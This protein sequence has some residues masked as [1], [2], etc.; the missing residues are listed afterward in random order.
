MRKM[1]S[2]LG[3]NSS[4]RRCPHNKQVNDECSRCICFQ[5][6]CQFFNS[7]S[8]EMT[9][10]LSTFFI[11]TQTSR[12]AGLATS[13]PQAALRGPSRLPRDSRLNREMSDRGNYHPTTR[14]NRETPATVDEGCSSGE[15]IRGANHPPL[16]PTPNQYQS[17]RTIAASSAV[18]VFPVADQSTRGCYLSWDR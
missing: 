10:F 8:H 13:P 2:P 16:L 14:N 3:F 12:Q 4:T 18:C 5:P 7:D 15:G 17:S 11:P 9:Q 6:P 1:Q